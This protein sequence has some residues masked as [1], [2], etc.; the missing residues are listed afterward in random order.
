MKDGV[1]Y[2]GIG[3]TWT[4]QNELQVVIS[5]D[6]RLE[7]IHGAHDDVGNLGLKKMLDILSD[8]F[9]WPNM[10]AIATYN[11]CTCEWCLKLKS[12]P[13]K[14]E[15]YQLLATYPLELVHMD[16]LTIENPHT[17]ADMNV[18]VIMD[19]FLQYAKAIV[20]PNQSVKATAIAFWNEFIMNCSFPEKLLTDQEHNFKSPKVLYRMAHICKVQTTHYLR[21]TL[22][23]QWK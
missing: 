10:E 5:S 23:M 2:Q 6:C 15:L 11:V 1:L 14:V 18:M 7:A 13:D 17:H 21:A 20:T 4:N 8:R 16:F 3:W 22:Y 19:Y 12:K 9:C